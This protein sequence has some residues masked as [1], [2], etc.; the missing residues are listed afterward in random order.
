MEEEREECKIGLGL[1]L[2]IGS[3]PIPHDHHK[4]H[5]LFP[6][7][8]PP[9]S[10]EEEEEEEEEGRG[11]G[12]KR[13]RRSSVEEEAK[14]K[15]RLTQEQASLL[16]DT[17]REHNTLSSVSLQASLIV[18]LDLLYLICLLLIID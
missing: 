9:I 14:K 13:L 7:R 1:G 17:F 3:T 15:L 6:P 4:L 16:E 12:S 5:I 8:P 10:K 11:G 2:A 18:I